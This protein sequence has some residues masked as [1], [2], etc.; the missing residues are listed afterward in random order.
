MDLVTLD[1]SAVPEPDA[2]AGAR[3]E[4]IGPHQT[5]DTLARE[6]GTLP[7]EIYTRLGARIERRYVGE[8]R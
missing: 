3:V 1:V 2:H 6:A 4:F 7:Y 8:A 5:V